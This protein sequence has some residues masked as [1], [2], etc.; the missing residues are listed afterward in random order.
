MNKL[1]II[2]DLA[3]KLHNANNSVQTAKRLY[4][5]KIKEYEDEEGEL[6]GKLDKW[7]PDHQE[8]RDFTKFSY[9]FYKDA[10]RRHKN[11]KA[12]LDRVCRNV[13]K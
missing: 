13:G 10:K 4:Y 2:C 7:H 9:L 1:E 11:I 3:L 5:D 6:I 12:R 8:A